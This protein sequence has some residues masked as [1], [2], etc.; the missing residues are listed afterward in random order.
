MIPYIPQPLWRCGPFTIHAFGVM[1]AV[2]LVLGFWLVRRKAGRRSL[3]PDWIGIVYVIAVLCGL[4]VAAVWG[5]I[6]RGGGVSFTGLMAGGVVAAALLMLREPANFWVTADVF[7]LTFPPV[8]AIA[9]FGCF[10]A[11][12]HIGA[13]TTSWIG[14]Q[15]P[16]GTRFD[17]GLLYSISAG[18]TA[19]IIALMDRRRRPSGVL[20]GAALALLGAGRLIISRYGHAVPS[21]EAFAIAMV[22]SAAI[23]IAV[24]YPNSARLRCRVSP[25][26]GKERGPALH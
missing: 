9:R 6:A 24:R 15:F 16:G 2:A 7:A 10:L 14:V 11:H 18:A 17:L 21:D 13:R 5:K 4:I 26:T 12:D 25:E 8:I 1:A 23:L 3:K 22:A 19:V 20:T